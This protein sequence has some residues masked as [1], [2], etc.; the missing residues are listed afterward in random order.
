MKESK[1][2][3]IIVK[4]INKEANIEELEKLESWLKNHE[5]TPLFDRFVEVELLTA[6][7]MGDYN[8][9]K[10][11]E[12]VKIRL[13]NENLKIRNKL[14]KK[15]AVA[16]S[17][18]LI[19]GSSIYQF[20]NGFIKKGKIVN[21]KN[22][23]NVGSVKAI[24]TLGNGDQVSLEKDKKYQTKN[25]SVEGEKLVYYRNAHA[26]KVNQKIEYNYLSVPRGGEY[27][28]VLSDGTKIKLNSDSKL[29]YPTTFIEGKPRNVELIYGEAYFEVSPSSEH[30][31]S[32]FNLDSKGQ[33]VSVLGT[34]FNVK[35]YDEDSEITTTLVT[36]KIT[37]QKGEVKKIL[38]PNQQSKISHGSDIIN[39]SE[40]DVS[41]EIAW[42][43]GLFTFNEMTLDEMMKVLSR[44]YDATII[45]E[46][47]KQKQ[48]VFTGILE[49]TESIKDI[50][51]N[52][53]DTSEGEISFEIT[54]K[55]VIIK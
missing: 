37:V 9:K 45:F 13:K 53:E 4:F 52:I 18:V 51:K 22:E 34:E 44:W 16:A 30:G 17:I 46:S 50:L 29:K 1:I 2:Q 3:K 49:R 5:N 20:K 38:K 35:A 55:T 36:G 42:V 14:F 12:K 7:C 24:L 43:N 25:V 6:I 39:V 33:L 21:S 11:K 27:L 31:G 54:N 26:N 41:E 40:V 47:A 32:L 48:F 10:A 23:I 15:I 19:I 8:L 28:V